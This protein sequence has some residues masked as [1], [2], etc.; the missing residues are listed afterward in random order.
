VEIESEGIDSTHTLVEEVDTSKDTSKD[1]SNVSKSVNVD[2]DLDDIVDS[3][4]LSKLI[5]KEDIKEKEKEESSK[6]VLSAVKD[7]NPV[8][9][10][11]SIAKRKALEQEIVRQTEE[12]DRLAEITRKKKEKE[13]GMTK[14]KEDKTKTAT[15]CISTG[16][17][18]SETSITSR[19][20]KLSKSDWLRIIRCM[21]LTS[22]GVC[23]GKLDCVV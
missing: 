21:I 11:K 18:S 16:S 23:V 22:L 1:S 9:R 12:F 14:S 17:H 2:Q 13:T 7:Y 5:P 8:E 19:K 4:D 3:I 15:T 6:R 10:E 20:S